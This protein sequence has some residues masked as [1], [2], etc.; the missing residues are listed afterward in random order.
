MAEVPLSA[1]AVLPAP[2]PVCGGDIDSLCDLIADAEASATECQEHA[3]SA[4]QALSS[5][6][7]RAVRALEARLGHL[8]H[9]A[10]LVERSAA[11]AL[12]A[13]QGYA[14][15]VAQIHAL[16][17]A[18]EEEVGLLLV[19]V[20]TNVGVISEIAFRKGIGGGADWRTPPPLFMPVAP[21]APDPAAPTLAN[22]ADSFNWS[23]AVSA[24]TG[25]LAQIDGAC[26]RWRGL[27]TQREESERALVGALARTVLVAAGPG[28]SAPASAVVSSLT[29]LLSTARPWEPPSVRLLLGGTLTP[30]EAAQTWQQLEAEGTDLVDLVDRYSC[31]LAGLDGLPFAVRDQA[32]RAA[33]DYALSGTTE[34]GHTFARLGLS[35]GDMSLADFRRDL[36]AVRDAVN[37][38]TD[39]ATGTG[40]IVQLAS[41]GVHDGAVTAAISVGDLDTA[42]RV[43]VFVSGMNSSVRGM[44]Y[45][46]PGI[47]EIQDGVGDV[48]MVNW[49]GYRSPSIAEEAFQ[50]RAERGSW[51][52][53]SFLDG[54]TASRSGAPPTRFALLGHSYGTNVAAEALKLGGHSVDTFVSIGSAGLKNGTTSGDLGVDEI[55]ATHADG[56]NIAPFGQKFHFRETSDGGL[57]YLPRVDPRDLEGAATFSSE[58]SPDG[59]RV[60]MHNLALPLDWGSAQWAADSLDGVAKA[61]EIGY[62]DPASTTVKHLKRIMKGTP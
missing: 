60:T 20:R 45:A 44:A 16:A 53:A 3:G 35:P 2:S 59:K 50:N 48:A 6:R 40:A 13:A 19:R 49:I 15:A 1:A 32:A 57:G 31:E 39:S 47:Q 17:Q 5:A 30:A 56:D 12:L 43:G 7:G 23:Q 24:W 18:V 29:G 36:V 54:I 8:Q 27:V 22:D 28:G 62:L 38:A 46:F 41:L 51:T 58:A 37:Q 26:V 11:S 55:H 33:L 42:S 9:S 14:R 52:L 34:L 21:G 61:D 4:D 10:S 25:A